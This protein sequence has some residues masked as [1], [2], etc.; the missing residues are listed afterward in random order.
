MY[1]H[2][3]CSFCAVREFFG[4]KLG[5]FAPIFEQ[6]FRKFGVFGGFRA[7]FHQFK[8]QYS[9][10][11]SFFLFAFVLTGARLGFFEISWSEMRIFFCSFTALGSNNV[12]LGKNFQKSVILDGFLLVARG[13]NRLSS[14]FR[15]FF[16]AIFCMHYFSRC[17]IYIFT[18]II[19]AQ[20][21]FLALVSQVF[22]SIFCIFGVLSSKNCLFCRILG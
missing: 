19:L 22:G 14:H 8:G 20:I 10:F 9:L 21:V 5:V 3:L 13:Q 2:F 11:G 17:I 6:I 18:Q 15:G 16:S 7:L 4:R 12:I 1:L